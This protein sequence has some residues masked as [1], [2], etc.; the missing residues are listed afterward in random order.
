MS[1][2]IPANIYAVIKTWQ[3]QRKT[4]QIALNLSEGRI[5]NAETKER[6]LAK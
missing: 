3:E 1:D 6:I 5:L 4:G 2:A